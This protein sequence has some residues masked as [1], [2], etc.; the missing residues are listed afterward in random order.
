MKADELL[1]EHNSRFGSFLQVRT[2]RSLVLRCNV[3]LLSDSDCC[4]TEEGSPDTDTASSCEYSVLP[5]L[6]L[7]F[8]LLCLQDSA[9]GCADAVGGQVSLLARLYTLVRSSKPQR[10][11]F[12]KIFLRHFEDYEVGRQCRNLMKCSSFSLTEKFS[13]Y[14]VVL[15]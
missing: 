12:L 5:R 14:A 15:G 3:C 9:R 8:F 6:F 7:Y 11:A 10:R 2:V 1:T 13:Q 4:W